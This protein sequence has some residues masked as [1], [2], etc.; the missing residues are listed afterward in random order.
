M[1]LLK[2]CESRLP[3]IA[4]VAERELVV[5]SPRLLA[6]V[7]FAEREDERRGAREV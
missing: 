2:S 6:V 7:E 4:A 5:R 1:S 3:P